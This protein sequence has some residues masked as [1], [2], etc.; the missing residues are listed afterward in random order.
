MPGSKDRDDVRV[1]FSAFGVFDGHGG[2]QVAT[3]VSHH[4]LPYVLNELDATACDLVAQTVADESG[5]EKSSGDAAEAPSFDEK[6][7]LTAIPPPARAIARAQDLFARS[8][9]PALEAGFVRSDAEACQRFKSGGGSTATLLFVTGWHIV[10]ASVGD[11]LAVLDTGSECRV[12]SASHRLDDSA[13]ERERVLRC[14]SEVEQSSVNGRPVGPLRVW[15]G[16]LAM[17]RTLGDA[18]AGAAVSPVPEVRRCVAPPQGGRLIVGSDGLWDA[19]PP[20]AA[21]QCARGA[22]SALEAAQKLLA[23]AIKRDKLKDDVTVIVVDLAP[24]P[25]PR[26]AR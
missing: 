2:R 5:D 8:L 26:T 17:S 18:A 24:A 12:L 4:L 14:G 19:L 16:G 13:P 22:A 15:P 21:V 20:K 3:F 23:A 6:D 9:G 11:S 25:R 10:V 1:P 7:P